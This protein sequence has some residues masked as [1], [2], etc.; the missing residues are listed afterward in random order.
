MIYQYEFLS[1]IT[2]YPIEVQPH[3]QMEDSVYQG[4]MG[5][6]TSLKKKLS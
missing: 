2:L 5:F 6:Y 4:S 3:I 1:D